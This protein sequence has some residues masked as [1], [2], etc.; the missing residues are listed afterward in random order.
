MPLPS[1]PRLMNLLHA[2]FTAVQYLFHLSDQRFYI[3]KNMCTYT[4]I[5]LPTLCINYRCYQIILQV[6]YFYTNQERCEVLTGYLSLGRRPGGDGVNTW[7]WTERLLSKQEIIA[8]IRTAT[9]AS[10]SR[11]SKRILLEMRVI[12][13]LWINCTIINRLINALIIIIIIIIIIQ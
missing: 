12:I 5:W 1:R 10:L 2:V 11:S 13:L 4:P 7:H 6:K 3:M 9:F 8:A